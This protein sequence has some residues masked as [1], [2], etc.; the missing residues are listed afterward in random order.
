MDTIVE[1]S[2]EE[3]DIFETMQMMGVRIARK[4][5]AEIDDLARMKAD[6]LGGTPSR[7]AMIL[8]MIDYSKAHIMAKYA[9]KKRKKR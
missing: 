9:A 6:R 1:T 8:E 4:T 2:K 3:L 5:V 7:T